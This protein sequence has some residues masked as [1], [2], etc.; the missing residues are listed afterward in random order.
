MTRIRFDKLE[1]GLGETVDV[2]AELP[3]TEEEHVDVDIISD[4]GKLE[5]Y[6][7]KRLK[8]VA[9]IFV[10][11]VRLVGADK[12]AS[13][14]G[15]SDGL[16]P[17]L[18]GG[19]LRAV[20]LYGGQKV[21]FR[22]VVVAILPEIVFD[23]D[24]YSPFDLVIIS[25]IS[26]DSNEDPDVIEKIPVL[27]ASSS[28]SLGI[29]EFNETGPNTGIFEHEFRLT[30]DKKK[31]PDDLQAKR[32][33]GIT[34][35]FRIDK[36]TTATKSAFVNYHVGQIMFD[37]DLAR[38]YE[39][40]VLRVI[41]P[42]ENRNPDAIDIVDVRIW[43]TT[44]TKGLSLKLRETGDRTGIFE[45]IISFTLDGKSKGLTLRVSDGDTVTAQ[46][47]DSTLPLPAELESLITTIQKE[48]LFASILVGTVTTRK[49]RLV[50]E[51]I[52]EE[53]FVVVEGDHD[54]VFLNSLLHKCFPN[55]VS[56]KDQGFDIIKASKEEQNY[57]I[58]SLATTGKSIK[59]FRDVD[60]KF[61]LKEE[62]K[63]C[64]QAMYSKSKLRSENE[65]KVIRI[66][67]GSNVH[68]VGLGLPNDEELKQLGI[69]HHSFEDYLLKLISKDTSVASWAGY[70][71]RDLRDH[72]DPLKNLNVSLVKSKTLLITLA[73]L[74][75]I[76]Y[77]ECIK[78]IVSLAD[79]KNLL[80]VT[81]DILPFFINIRQS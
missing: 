67:S 66:S 20:L 61:D 71:L 68:I 29:V 60:D 18:R 79:M 1:Y 35:E 62:I 16:L 22:A 65:G 58:A 21:E 46:Y 19:D 41:D 80:E 37:K 27:I 69:T 33:D 36:K 50:I 72:A 63:K 76:S 17:A 26:P 77:E 31:F 56:L 45:E 42:D 39:R 30:L 13:G 48:T 64:E 49:V 78:T 10:G 24:E 52:R 43:S 6:K 70:S 74:N 4:V 23:K 2:I 32:G 11:T 44:D 3:S 47:V 7:L 75:K 9:D 55:I 40:A 12:T 53:A 51:P 38:P 14:L 25:I 73:M 59:A 34:A 5:N 28:E 8:D 54:E 81:K 15:P 57:I